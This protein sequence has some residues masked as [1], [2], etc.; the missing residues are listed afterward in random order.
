MLV[1]SWTIYEKFE[2]YLITII[3]ETL[4]CAGST[5]SSESSYSKLTNLKINPLAQVTSAPHMHHSFWFTRKNTR[6][7]L[8][9]NNPQHQHI[10]A[11]VW[12]QIMSL[13]TF[14]RPQ[15]RG[16]RNGVGSG[17]PYSKGLLASVR[18]LAEDCGA[19]GAKGVHFCV[20]ARFAL[21]CMVQRFFVAANL[22]E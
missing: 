6:A 19:F 2:E 21:N 16:G 5:W 12:T 14:A 11:F 17:A 8:Q 3:G 18:L 4:H 13:C 9:N 15:I 20:F 10:P 1:C 22:W 7:R